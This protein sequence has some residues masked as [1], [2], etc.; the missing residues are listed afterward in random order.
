MRAKNDLL[1]WLEIMR[2]YSWPATF[3]PVF[4]G[5][6]LASWK[7]EISL[8]LLAVILLG[9]I[10][11]HSAANF[12]NEYFDCRA[13]VDVPDTQN[14]SEVLLEGRLNPRQVY[15]A[16]RAVMIIFLLTALIFSI[17][18]SRMGIILFA[19]M[20]V[21]GAYFYTAPPF[22]LK[23]R[24]FGAAGAFIFFGWL[25]PQAVFYTLAGELSPNMV[26]LYVF[27]PGLLIAAILHGNNM[28][29]LETDAG[30]I[31]TLAILLGE[32]WGKLLFYIL[33]FSPYMFALI[34]IFAGLLSNSAFIVFFSLPLALKIA[35]RFVKAEDLQ[36]ELLARID[37]KTA[38]LQAFFGTLWLFSLLLK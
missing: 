21:F 37:E 18:L 9:V 33:I 3:A 23:Y 12:L 22:S 5:A 1:N 4:M 20:G 36:Y 8:S 14:T 24:G 31:V 15:L 6:V 30:K 16:G 38:A 26:F 10:A 7:G 25:L 27:P 29:D 28:R 11:L 13:G 35:W 2:P 19:L 34:Y 17:M 32:R